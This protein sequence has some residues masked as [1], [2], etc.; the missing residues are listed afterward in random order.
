MAD[1]MK[2]AIPQLRDFDQLSSQELMQ[3]GD[4]YYGQANQSDSALICYSIVANRYYTTSKHDT[5]QLQLASKAMNQLGILYSHYY[6][7]YQKAHQYLLM[8]QEIA[9]KNDFRKLKVSILVNLANIYLLN[10][11]MHE[12]INQNTFD[13]HREAYF[14]AI[15]EK[16][17]QAIIPATFNYAVLGNDDK[18]AKTVTDDLDVFFQLDIPDTIEDK[19]FLTE[20][21]QAVKAGSNND[22]EQA[23]SLYEKSFQHI[24]DHNRVAADIYRTN[25]RHEKCRLLIKMGR[26]EEAVNLMKE[27]I[28]KAKEQNDHVIQYICYM[29]LSNYFAESNRLDEAKENELMAL[30]QKDV[31][32]NENNLLEADKAGLFF[33]IN[34]MNEEMKSL[35]YERR[36]H[37]FLTGGAIVITLLVLFVLFLLYKKNRQTMEN[38]Q[39]LYQTNLKL[40]ATDEERRH[41]LMEQQLQSETYDDKLQQKYQT[42]QMNAQMQSD[43][44][45][46]ILYVM[47]TSP[48]VYTDTFSLRRLAEL[49]GVAQTNY[50]SQVINDHYKR[51]FPVL[52]NEYRI[53]EACRRM[54]D[55]ERYGHLTNEAIAQDVGFRSYP[56]FVSNFKKFTGL[57]PSAYRKQATAEIVRT[58]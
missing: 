27:T 57:T 49:V 17:W 55:R 37:R 8:A 28:Q 4:Y 36:I 30:R 35:Y 38:N 6:H 19:L 41:L 29:G 9:Q 13:F 10:S 42:H 34:K 31:V 51:T 15:A 46:R 24:S 18:R 50:V 14:A 5:F 43:L 40:L 39:R 52:L 53:C 56:N 32:M 33:Q 48:E 16:Y 20:F 1:G 22:Y 47:E 3:K 54:N 7:D 26:G 11:A 21:C 12:T 23:L 44:L 58:A 2:N 45:H 25:I